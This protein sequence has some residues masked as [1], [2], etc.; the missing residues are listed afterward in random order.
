MSN[1]KGINTKFPAVFDACFL[2]PE[3]GEALNNK[4]HALLSAMTAEEKAGLCH[5]DLDPPDPGKIANGGYLRGVPRLGVPEIRMFDGPAGVTSIYDTTGLPAEELLAST[6]SRKLAK[7]FGRVT[8]SENRIISGNFQLGAEADLCRTTHFNRTRDMLG[9]DPFLAGEMIVPLV[10]GI[11]E[12]GVAAVL[13]HLAAYII[14]SNPADAPNTVVDEQTMRELYLTPFEKGIKVGGAVGVMTAYSRING[15]YASNSRSLQLDVLRR[16]WD[17]KGITM[18]DWGGNHSFTLKNGNDIEMPFG[19]YNSTERILQRLE[20]G[21]LTMDELDTAAGHVLWALGRIGYLSLV[22]L[23]EHGTAAEE[24][25]RTE[26]IRLSDTYSETPALREENAKIAEEIAL[27]GAVMLKNKNNALPLQDGSAFH[28]ARIAMI[29]TGAVYPVCGYGQERAYGTISRMESPVEA[30]KRLSGPENS[31]ITA[32][33][34]DLVGRTVPADCLFT[35]EA[36]ITNGL[37]RTYGITEDDGFRPPIMSQGGEG[38]EFFGTASRDETAEEEEG[39][40][41]FAPEELFLP[42]NDKAD[43]QGYETGSF[44]GID[45]VIEFICDNRHWKNGPQGTAFTKG[46]AYTWKGWLRAPETGEYQINLQAIGG[47]S[48]LKIDTDGTGL[49]DIGVIKMREG[50]QWPWGNL[51]CTPEGMEVCNTRIY[52]EA[53][54]A[55]PILLYVKAE[56]DEKDMQVRLAWVTPSERE[57]DLKE[58]ELAAASADASV[59]F[60]HNGFKISREMSKGGLQF[61][62]GTDLSLD[63]EQ[64][65]LLSCIAASKKTQ[66]KLIAAVCNGSSFAMQDWIDL[67]DALIWLWMPGQAGGSALAKLLLGKENPSGKLPQSFPARN[68]DTPVTD[69]PE[70]KA[71]RWDGMIVPGKPREVTASEGIFTGYRWHRKNNIKPLFPFGFGLSY[72][73]FDYTDLSVEQNGEDLTVF[74]CITNSGEVRGSEIAQVY[75]GKGS[76]PDYAMIA[77]RQLCGF[78]RLDDLDPGESRNVKI[79]IPKRCFCYW[80]I[81]ETGNVNAH[82]KMAGGPREILVGASSEDIRLKTVIGYK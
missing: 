35:D 50:S 75:L 82:W 78:M 22:T 42:G 9:E 81:H 56:M 61:N 10:Q 53:N 65:K 16:D 80:D 44:C 26:P 12:E 33:G 77:D 60:L 14:S 23:D 79:T 43:M 36:C 5:G 55:Y 72:T 27:R 3:S 54:K 31:I 20:D 67:P 30:V 69:T 66:G 59:I 51:V 2:N 52:L 34:L 57:A 58:A 62:E 47:I 8:G 68:T 41:D 74:F 48:V 39:S 71:E 64:K 25:G 7:E 49:K 21:R 18:C 76:V 19:A 24:S 15:T 29:G 40:L 1:N 6:W 4:V 32:I 37:I 38:A 70:H 73:H 63:E 17:F 28:G 45:R 11:Q 13:K 46:E